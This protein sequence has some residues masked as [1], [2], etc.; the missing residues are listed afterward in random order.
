VVT[1]RSSVRAAS[2]IV[3]SS[4]RRWLAGVNTVHAAP[5][6][7]LAEKIVDA[8][9]TYCSIQRDV[10]Y[11]TEWGREYARRQVLVYLR[12]AGLEVDSGEA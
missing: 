8:L 9:S 4:R 1:I 12:E 11:G 3:R 7:N 5:G 2:G 6:P 10:I